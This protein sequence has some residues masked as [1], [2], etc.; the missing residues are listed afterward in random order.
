ML[1]NLNYIIKI[2]E[3]ED[4][5]KNGFYF[6]YYF[7]FRGR[8]YAD[9]PISYTHNRFFRHVYTYGE[10]TLEEIQNFEISLSEIDYPHINLIEQTSGVTVRYPLIN[11]TKK[12]NKF[13]VHHIFFEFGKLFKNKL[14][15]ERGGRADYVDFINLG[16]E[17]FCNASIGLEEIDKQ[18]EY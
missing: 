16:I 13:L 3:L 2:S 9:S 14:S 8:L 12:F 1:Y 15:F 11:L 7:D 10:Y 18:I 6:T 4:F 5:L 17:V